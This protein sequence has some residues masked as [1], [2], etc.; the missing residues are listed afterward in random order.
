MS[1]LMM[2]VQEVEKIRH[3]ELGASTYQLALASTSR[4][5]IDGC[6]ECRPIIERAE[7]DYAIAKLRVVGRWPVTPHGINL[8]IRN[9]RQLSTVVEMPTGVAQDGYKVGEG[10]LP[11]R[12]NVFAKCIAD[13]L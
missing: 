5:E 10:G 11:L 9:G 7:F 8:N 4:A 3:S 12:G 2:H 13:A 6:N 1:A